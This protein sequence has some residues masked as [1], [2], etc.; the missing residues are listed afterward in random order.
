MQTKPKIADLLCDRRRFSERVVTKNNGAC[1][2]GISQLGIVA[3]DSELARTSN[4]MI[5]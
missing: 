2:V 5:D 3:A 4:K 1:S